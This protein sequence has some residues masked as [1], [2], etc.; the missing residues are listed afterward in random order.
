MR[1]KTIMLLLLV[2]L[3]S[4]SQNEST[5]LSKKEQRKERPAYIGITSG[6]SFSSFRDFATSPLTYNGSPLYLSLSRTKVD[7]KRE[8]EFEF[9]Y[10]FGNYTK[11]FN[12]QFNTSQ[13]KTASLYYSQLYRLDKLSSEQFNVKI[14]GQFNISRNI[15]V[16]ESMWNNSVGAEVFPNL[17]GSIKIIKDISRKEEKDKRF[18]FLK[19]RLNQRTRNLAFRLNIGLINSSYRNG[20]AYT[21]QT[22]DLN[23]L[24]LYE[25][26][27][28]K[29][30]SGFRLSSSFDYTIS[31]K[32][33]NAI[34]LSYLWDAYKT[35]GNL[36]KFEMASHIFKFTFLFNTNNR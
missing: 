17:A 5:T 33:K 14:G 25:G 10:A 32:N 19:Y 6:L 11:I 27:Q 24:N 26:Y 21:R 34:Q 31:L 36:D 12:F 7:K 3:V 35:G 30:L 18:L 9:S 16:N 13:V 22:I 29:L 23:G 1:E 2:P 4:F 15:R 28:F 20:Y 8:S